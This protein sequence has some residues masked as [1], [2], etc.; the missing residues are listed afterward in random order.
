MLTL[1]L[2]AVEAGSQVS[3]AEI[4]ASD[5]PDVDST[6]GD[7]IS[8]QDDPAITALTVDRAADPDVSHG[9]LRL[10]LAHRSLPACSLGSGCSHSAF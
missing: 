3:T 1:R 10:G 4:T 5:V 6:P 2:Q 9:Q 8:G 7:T